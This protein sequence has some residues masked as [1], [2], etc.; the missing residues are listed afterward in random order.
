MTGPS[1]KQGPPTE[2]VQFSLSRPTFSAWATQFN[3][4]ELLAH[5]IWTSVTA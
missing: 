4:R 3:S 2:K 1:L 5:T